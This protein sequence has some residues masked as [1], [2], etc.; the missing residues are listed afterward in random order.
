MEENVCE[1]HLNTNAILVVSGDENTFLLQS[2]EPGYG[3][4]MRVGGIYLIYWKT[5][6]NSH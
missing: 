4:R 2:N 6:L 5:S 1:Q 3:A